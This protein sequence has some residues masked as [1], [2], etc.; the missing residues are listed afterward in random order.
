MSGALDQRTEVIPASGTLQLSPANFIFVIT[1]TGNA[2]LKLQRSGIQKGANQENYGSSQLAGLQISRTQ[3]WD[4]AQ[5]SGAPGVSVTFIYG[6][7]DVREDVT[8]FNQQIATVAG[9]VAVATSPSATLADTADTAQASGTQTVIAA[10]LLRRRITIGVLS[11]GGNSVRVSQAGG[12]GRGLEIQPGMFTEF[13]T[14]AAL[15]VRNDNTNG[16]GASTTWYALE[17]T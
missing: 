7:T 12:A 9:V 13:D 11:T 17:E 3:R 2:S 5:I 1:S 4:W 6:T 10:N 15:T 8:Q 16:S 14:T